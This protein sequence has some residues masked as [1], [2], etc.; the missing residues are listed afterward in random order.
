M[1]QKQANQAEIKEGFSFL[2]KETYEAL[3]LTRWLDKSGHPIPRHPEL[4]VEKAA[5][6]KI[7]SKKDPVPLDLLLRSNLVQQELSRM[8]INSISLLD[9]TVQVTPQVMRMLGGLLEREV[10]RDDAEWAAAMASLTISEK[11]KIMPSRR[12]HK[13]NERDCRTIVQQLV[14][15]IPHEVLTSTSYGR[16]EQGNDTQKKTVTFEDQEKEGEKVER[17]LVQDCLSGETDG[18]KNRRF[19]DQHPGQGS[20]SGESDV[21]A[22]VSDEKQDLENR[23][24]SGEF[25]W[26]RRRHRTDLEEGTCSIA[27]SSMDHNSWNSGI[28]T[29]SDKNSSPGSE[30][31]ELAIH[32]LLVETRARNQ[33]REVYQKPD[34]DRYLK[35][36][37]RVFDN[38]ADDLETKA[39]SKRSISLLP[40][41]R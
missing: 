6:L 35:P 40:Q 19:Q 30:L 29:Y 15:S 9:K 17:N 16:K 4:P 1:E 8:N 14:S 32:A 31:S 3:P 36:G 13:E 20:L 5:E 28:D 11:V 26:M 24:L 37:G 2:D 18:E 38:S 21:D 39:V 22:K 27:D 33:D 7:L 34:S 25:R 12:Q 10:T 23:F 41:K